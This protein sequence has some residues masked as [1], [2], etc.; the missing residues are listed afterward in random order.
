M[1]LFNMRL[2]STSGPPP[3]ELPQVHLPSHQQHT[4]VKETRK[5]DNLISNSNTNN[6]STF[7]LYLVNL[8]ECL[9]FVFEIGFSYCKVFNSFNSKRPDKITPPKTQCIIIYQKQWRNRRGGG[10][11]QCAPQRLLTGKFLL[12]YREKKARKNRKGG[13]MEK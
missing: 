2:S 3:P 11:G 6:D 13:K 9:K 12:T 5:H 4:A 7:T 1:T 8:C 10:R